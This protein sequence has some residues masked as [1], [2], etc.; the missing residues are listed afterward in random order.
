MDKERTGGLNRDEK[1]ALSLT[2]SG[3]R[4]DN[5]VKEVGISR[6]TLWR[7]RNREEAKKYLEEQMERLMEAVPDIVGGVL[8]EIKSAG[9]LRRWLLNDKNGGNKTKL[10]SSS[11]VLKYLDGV[12]KKEG[13]VLRAVGMYPSQS[14]SLVIQNIFQQVIN[15]AIISPDVMK[16]IGPLMTKLAEGDGGQN[17]EIIEGEI[18]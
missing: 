17:S 1:K 9:E 10:Q 15:T 8:E 11:D 12:A 13:D 18:D 5:I 6:T 14:T 4:Q 7:L 16:A 2:A 3:M